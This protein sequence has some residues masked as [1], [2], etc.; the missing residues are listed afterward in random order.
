MN[1]PAIQ[2]KAEAQG[3]IEALHGMADNYH[4]MHNP[5][6]GEDQEI[7]VSAYNCIQEDIEVIISDIESATAFPL[8]L[9]LH[10]AAEDQFIIAY[11][12]YHDDRAFYDECATW[13]AEGGAERSY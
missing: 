10:T 6:F 7:R 2:T 13:R 12:Q 5:M 8:V 1:I 9:S 4:D 3:I 11:E